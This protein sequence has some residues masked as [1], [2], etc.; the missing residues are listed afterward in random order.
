MFQPIKFYSR[1]DFVS[2]TVSIYQL[3]EINSLVGICF[4]K[5]IEYLEENIRK[6]LNRLQETIKYQKMNRVQNTRTEIWKQ[7][8]C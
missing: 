8:S 7:Q 5:A 2:F 6:S 1:N 4:L 3:S